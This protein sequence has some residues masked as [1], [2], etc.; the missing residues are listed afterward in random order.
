MDTA[1]SRAVIQVLAEAL[2]LGDRGN[3]LTAQSPLLGAVPEFDSMAVLT[4]ITRLE[5]AFD[6]R[7]A[8]DEISADTFETVASVIAYVES[9][10]G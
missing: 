10:R 3:S 5:E 7:I 8:D 1:V 2:A 9:K 4:V 6:I